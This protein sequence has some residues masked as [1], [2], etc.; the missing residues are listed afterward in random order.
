MGRDN[1]P[2]FPLGLENL[3]LKQGLQPNWVKE[4]SKQQGRW[5]SGVQRNASVTAGLTSQPG[6]SGCLCWVIPDS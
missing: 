4:P 3:L 1:H 2:L 5:P 6:E